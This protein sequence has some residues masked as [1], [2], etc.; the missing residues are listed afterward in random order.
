MKA[1]ETNILNFIGG[2]NKSFVIPP[3]QRNY[4][5]TESQC[6]DLFEDILKAAN[7]CQSHYLGNIIYYQ[8]GNNGVSFNEFIL[9]DGQ[10][11][12]T[13]ILILLCALRDM[14]NEDAI[15]REINLLY[16]KNTIVGGDGGPTFRIRLK[17]TDYDNGCFEHLVNEEPQE[18]E[19]NRIFLNYRYFRNLIESSNVDIRRIYN[20]ISRLEVVDINLQVNSLETVQTV[21]EKIN[22]TGKPLSSA[23]LIRNYL[24]ISDDVNQQ[25]RLYQTYWV[26]IE[27]TIT[28]EHVSRFVKDY[29]MMKICD[30]VK[31]DNV[32]KDFK[33]YV[34][35]L[36]HETVLNDMRQYAPFYIKLITNDY[37]N[38]N[39][40]REIEILN[41]LKAS[42][43]YSLLMYILKRCSDEGTD[44]IEI[45]HL[46]RCFLS[47]RRIVGSTGG[48]ALEAVV[49]SLI[50]KLQADEIECTFE[51]IYQELSKSSRYPDDAE[52]KDALMSSKK[53]NH[54]YG[55][56]ILLAIEESETQNI[57]VDFGQVT[58]EHL[59]PQKLSTWWQTNLGG[60]EAADETFKRYLHCIGNLAP[61]SGAYNSRNSNRPWPEKVQ[62]MRGVQFSVT[63]E[64]LQLPS[65]NQET[66]ENRNENL[67]QRACRAILAPLPREIHLNNNAITGEA[68]P[69]SDMSIYMDGSSIRNISIDGNSIAV[70]RWNQLLVKVSEYVIAIDSEKF[71]RVVNENTIHKD[72][73][74]MNP[75]NFDPIITTDKSLVIS[76][77]RI[78]T[79]GFY[80]EGTISSARARYYTYLLL[81]EYN[82]DTVSTIVVDM[83]ENAD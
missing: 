80:V 55:R 69:I 41:Y 13:T 6:K 40:K 47:R 14:T 21:F 23:D 57:P 60:T 51:A 50:S 56:A 8:S 34:K 44:P 37:G 30:E 71:S 78:L 76:P 72:R 45:F 10:Q 29:L 1:T 82:L 54:N 74:R 46:I 20:I 38:D 79:T 17:Q 7:N 35:D 24:L 3:F 11:R 27:R 81:K 28:T 9:I 15:K 52:F 64:V 61:L 59:M 22:S 68:Y 36:S 2:F 12:I 70:S 62:I 18:N 83:Q 63:Q 42:E 48:G 67:A 65:W 32:Y 53:T 39:L 43:M 33:D 77:K 4:E 49:E 19:T 75:P 73:K 31:D 25:R 5:W 58:I 16:L 26:P 66:I